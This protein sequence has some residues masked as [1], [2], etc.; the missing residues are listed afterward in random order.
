MGNLLTKIKHI[1]IGTYNNIFNKEKELSKQR[2]IV[3]Y[4]CKDKKY[5]FGLGCICKKCGCILK[6]K[7]TIL[8]EK[9]PA[10]KW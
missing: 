9:C 6:S 3:C 5:L 4:M 10:G 2:L 1:I 8:D 7:T